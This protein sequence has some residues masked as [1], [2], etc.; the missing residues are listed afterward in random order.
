MTVEYKEK[1]KPADTGLATRW[2]KKVSPANS[3]PEYP[4]PQMRREE[5]L[6]LNGLWE[7]AITRAADKVTQY[8]GQ[9]LVPFPVES[10]LS[11]VQKPLRP[12]QC[13]WYKREFSVPQHWEDRSLLLHFGAV[14]WHAEVWVNGKRAGE[15]SGGYYPFSFDISSYIHKDEQSNEIMV[16]VRDSTETEQEQRGKQSLTPK[17]LFYTAVS[18]IWQT[19]WLEP[20]PKAYISS[21]K[22]T[23]DLDNGG[24]RIQLC[25]AQQHSNLHFQATAYWNGVETASACSEVDKELLLPIKD[26]QLWTP[27][28]P[29][30]Y[31]LTI[32][33]F[34]WEHELDRV[35]SYFAMRA[36]TIEKDQHGVKRLCLNHQPIFHNGILDQGYWPDGLYTAPTDE[37]LAFDIQAAKD[38]G[39]NMIR[40]HIK[41]EP[42]RWYMHCDQLGMIVWQDMINGGAGWN[43][44]HHL[45]LPN[46]ASAVIVDDRSTYKVMGRD[47]EHNREQFK[48]ELEEMI[49]A[50]YNVP[51][52]AVW[53]PF[54]E[55]WGQ[56]DAAEIAQWV[57]QL[58]PSRL[59]DHASGWHDQ[60]AGDM[61][62][63]HTYFRRLRM[64]R[65][66][67]IKDRVIVISEFGG[68]SL[69][70][71]GHLWLEG[72]G[73]GYK[74]C[75][76]RE[77]FNN[78]YRKL[79]LEQLKPLIAKGVSAAVYTQLTD[80]ET[81]INGVMTYDREMIKLDQQQAVI[82][83]KQLL[84]LQ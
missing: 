69:K 15:H 55:A 44:Y 72:K 78:A 9:I 42:A 7:Y 8:D 39:Y 3:L 43:N 35:N 47:S 77:G 32:V 37:A 4:R 66:K 81:E 46:F 79:M 14:D 41:I 36:F 25:S 65:V 56:F 71:D 62:S 19:V 54:N 57:K 16:C 34:E 12:E 82:I 50:L 75:K 11:G 2:A 31:D 84:A 76:T 45:F 60:G 52:I 30:L 20:V 10:A 48:Q 61:K 59:V 21:F 40:K 23:P 73:F 18:G 63:D 22:L 38:L 74:R 64:P 51:C 13:L 33:L 67:R 5:W 49:E 70:E 68:Y 24:L 6:N 29:H 27:D 17:G 58:D 26:P 1:W 28:T 83:H 80:V 53:V